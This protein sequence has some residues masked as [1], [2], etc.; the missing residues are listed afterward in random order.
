MSFWKP[1]EPLPDGMEE[2]RVEVTDSLPLGRLS[3]SQN[4]HKVKL[5]E[6][7]QNLPV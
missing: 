1:G 2:E 6:S 4:T 5:S 7:T 3:Q